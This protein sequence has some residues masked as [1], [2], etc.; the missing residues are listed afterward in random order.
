VSRAQVVSIGFR[1]STTQDLTHIGLA[2][3]PRRRRGRWL[4]TPALVL[5][6]LATGVGI[7][8]AI[9]DR[10][11]ASVP[12]PVAVAPEVQALRQQLEQ[13]RMG[14]RL[15]EARSHELERQIDSLNQ[16]LT[17]SQDELAFFR[18]AREGKH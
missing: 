2:V 13:A 11:M 7:G 6:A 9:H 4:V 1:R 10:T 14:S 3:T 5:L 16:R 12:Q 18:K 17:E 8:Y 15:S